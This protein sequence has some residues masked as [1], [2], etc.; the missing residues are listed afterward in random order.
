MYFTHQNMLC[1]NDRKVTLLYRMLIHL[2]QFTVL[3]VHLTN[4]NSCRSRFSQRWLRSGVHFWHVFFHILCWN[5]FN[6]RFPVS[7]TFACI[8]IF[9]IFRFVL[10]IRFC[11]HHLPS[12]FIESF[13]LLFY[14]ALYRAFWYSSFFWYSHV[15]A[16]AY[17]IVKYYVMILIKWPTKCNCVGYVYYSLV[18][19]LFYMFRV[20]LSLIIR[21]I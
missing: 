3:I 19:W 21:N 4:H 11:M 1:P 7:E 12:H 17:A 9:F 20:M 18:V 16:C 15:H 13:V 2:W 5:L 10:Y 14:I 8:R 6:K